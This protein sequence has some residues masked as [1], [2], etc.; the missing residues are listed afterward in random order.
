MQSS[1]FSH[2]DEIEMPAFYEFFAGGGMVRAGLGSEWSCLFAN[3]NDRKKAT[4]YAANWG[5]EA[6]CVRDVASVSVSELPA[7]ADLAWASFP[8]QDLSLAGSGAGLQGKRSGT[9]WSFWRLMTELAEEGRAPTIIVLENVCGALAS[10]KG[11]DFAKLSDALAGGGYRLGAMVIDAACFVPQSRR[12][13]FVTCVQEDAPIPPSLIAP[14]PDPKWHPPSLLSAYRTL[15]PRAKALW[16]WWTLPAPATR[17][18]VF[19]DVIEEEPRGVTWHTP[20]ETQRLLSMMSVRNLE[21]VEHARQSGRRMVGGVY[22]RMRIGEDGQRVQCA[23]VRFDDVS[24]CLRT[25]AGGSSRQTILLVEGE[26]VCSRLLAPREAARL[27]GLPDSYTLPENYNEAYH[28]AG[29]GV[30]IPAVHF[31]AERLLEPI[32]AAGK[33]K[34]IEVAGDPLFRRVEAR[35]RSQTGISAR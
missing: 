8:C 33:S 9:F 18:L 23:E 17:N 35:S 28:L 4:T 10:H 20:Q 15:S 13:L 11:R 21:K 14:E 6:L 31:L 30:V 25:P 3:D 2:Q 1:G 29:D 12:R 34:P 24:G 19:S 32:I 5:A 22:R 27:M 26:R 16:L 7:R